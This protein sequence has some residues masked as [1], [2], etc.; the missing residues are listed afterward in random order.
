[1]VREGRNA[2]YVRPGDIEG[3]SAA[4][5]RLLDDGALRGELSRANL[6]DVRRYDAAEIRRFLLDLYGAL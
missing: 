4:I 5:E 3:L 1:M 6:E 2:L